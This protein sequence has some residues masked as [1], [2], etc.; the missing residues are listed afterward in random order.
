MSPALTTQQR[1][2][3]VRRAWVLRLAFGG[4]LI[5]LSIWGMPLCRGLFRNS[6]GPGSLPTDASFT[7]LAAS[8][9]WLLFFGPLAAAG[10]VIAWSTLRKM[11][12][13]DSA[14]SWLYMR[15][16]SS[17]GLSANYPHPGD[18]I[19]INQLNPPSG[20]EN[21]SAESITRL[22]RI[23]TRTAVTLGGLAGT[24]LLGIGVFGLVSLLFFLHPTSNASVYSGLLTARMVIYFGVASGISVL[25]GLTILQR[26]FGR[27]NTG[28]LL[29][30]RV[31]TRLILQHRQP[32]PRA[33][34]ANR[35]PSER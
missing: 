20:L 12:A 14:T 23:G 28:W 3:S 1:S 11:G 19:S 26:T 10:V 30:L 4:A 7:I 15:T 29:P 27:E 16:G 8:I 6:L 31:F 5:G 21:L 33:K 34:S 35:P 17:N 13:F 32:D 22:H 25:L 18:M 24:F 2:K 9:A